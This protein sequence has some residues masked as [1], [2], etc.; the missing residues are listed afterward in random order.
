MDPVGDFLH[1][2]INKFPGEAA[3]KDDDPMWT[4]IHNVD[5]GK[6][7][8]TA[9]KRGQGRL[10]VRQLALAANG[11]DKDADDLY[12]TKLH[13]DMLMAAM[14]HQVLVGAQTAQQ[15][16]ERPLVR[17]PKSGA[18]VL[19]TTSRAVRQ[20]PHVDA[21]VRAGKPDPL[22]TRMPTTAAERRCR[23]SR[24]RAATTTLPWRPVRMGS[25]WLCIPAAFTLSIAWRRSWMSRIW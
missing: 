17:V 16:N 20:Q 8:E 7:D 9:M 21:T 13:C 2:V 5:L 11:D 24:A 12:K 25:L 18:R 10:T 14:A 19:L 15:L 6:V 23:R 4:P 1:S 3:L 22:L